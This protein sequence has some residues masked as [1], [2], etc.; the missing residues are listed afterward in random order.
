MNRPVDW[1]PLAEGD[2]VPGDPYEVAWLGRQFLATATEIKSAAQRLRTMCTDEFWD[3]DAGKAFRQRSNDTADKLD[4][5][6]AR[7][8]AAGTALG[9]DPGDSSPSTAARPN[10]AGALAEAQRIS[11]AALPAA[12][13][14]ACTRKAALSG[15]RTLA[16]KQDPIQIAS[17]F[18][19]IGLTPD[20][21]GHLVVTA[22]MKPEVQALRRQYNHAA[23]QIVTA[24]HQVARAQRLRDEA[25]AN[26]SNMITAAISRD[27]LGD[28]WWDH[29]TNFI[30]EH[31]G[32]L[33]LISEVA[34]WIATVC[35]TLAL[36]VGW[37]PI[38]GQALAAVLGTV[39]LIASVVTLIADV[40]LKIG[41]KGSWFDI[42]LDVIAV[43][44]F[45]L[46]RAATGALKDSALLARVVGRGALLANAEADL[47]SGDAWIK[48]GEEGLQSLLPKA[49]KD[50]SETVGEIDQEELS[51]A[52][53]HAPGAWP[54][55]G[56]IV[57]GFNPVSILQDGFKDVGDLKPSNW[58][59]LVG[60][61]AWQGAKFFVGDPEIH[62]ALQSVGSVSKVA[63]DPG[64]KS[65]LVKVA[66]NRNMWRYATDPALAADFTNHF[67]TE[68]GIKGG[69]LR[70]VGLGW[71]AG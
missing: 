42:A 38:I 15:L 60:K 67:L 34:G 53:A 35:G 37:I 55:W 11:A 21:S 27:G 49:W 9:K 36:F 50:A 63:D 71:A 43:A 44:S 2:P 46:G 5:A 13:D 7:Y 54:K 70:D 40:L 58:K 59:E 18:G 41:G 57:R 6:F 3:S 29:V 4:K 45:G 30:D 16:E 47:M 20:G 24:Q 65:Y 33:S 62:E 51:A 69:L 8:E 10:Y 66:S 19:T 56:D 68:T 32:L 64:V 26:A 61:D 39:A 28:S 17:P 52:K 1:S 48:G 22:Q 12:Q 14:A 23:D 31:A 25:A